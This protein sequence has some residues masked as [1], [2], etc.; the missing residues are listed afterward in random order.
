MLL[1]RVRVLVAV[2]EI[3]M[4]VMWR[5]PLAEKTQRLLPLAL[6]VAQLHRM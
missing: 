1:K 6:V 5:L 2:E 4:P 3:T